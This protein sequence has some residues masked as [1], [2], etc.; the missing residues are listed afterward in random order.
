MWRVEFGGPFS[1]KKLFN[2]ALSNN[3]FDCILNRTSNT[4]L[5]TWV[6]F[7]IVKNACNSFEK[8]LERQKIFKNLTL[9]KCFVTPP[10][11]QCRSSMRQKVPASYQKCHYAVKISFVELKFVLSRHTHKTWRNNYY[12]WYAFW[13]P[14]YGSIRFCVKRSLFTFSVL[15]NFYTWIYILEFSISQC[16][17]PSV[18]EE[19]NHFFPSDFSRSRDFFGKKF[20]V[21]WKA[22]SKH[23]PLQHFDFAMIARCR[24]KAKGKIVTVSI[25]THRAPNG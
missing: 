14:C 11:S 7:S 5:A 2:L 19:K 17:N 10:K 13:S 16:L 6:K 24:E 8:V 12:W 23:F 18:R 20:L 25:T 4:S 22:S 15:K 3:F 21:D 9:F 1:A